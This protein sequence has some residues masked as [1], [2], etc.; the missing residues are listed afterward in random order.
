MKKKETILKTA[1]RLFATQG[2]EATTTIQIA[3]EAG[4]TE[5]LIYYHFKGKDDLFTSII[6]ATFSEYFSRIDALEKKQGSPF[7]QIRKL[8]ELQ[9]DI[10][11]EM[12]DEVQLVA[13]ACPARLNDPE[14]ICAGN[15]KKYRRRL[16]EY[17]I[18]SLSEGIESSE[19][20]P[21]PLEETAILILSIIN[22]IVRYSRMNPDPEKDLRE[23][24]VEFCR[25]SLMN[26]NA[27]GS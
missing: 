9:Y 8:I 11:A 13:N 25:R 20:V 2:F 17:L 12:P 22:G 6:A 10:A 27:Q 15:V 1:A 14:D 3:R 19:F 26:N 5:P 24:A 18:R 4:V 23:A 7:G 16:L 21:V